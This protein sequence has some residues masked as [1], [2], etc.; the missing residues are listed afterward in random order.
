ITP[1]FP[2]EQS[3]TLCLA[4]LSL[5]TVIGSPSVWHAL[6]PRMAAN[7]AALA[8]ETPA[9]AQLEDQARGYYES[10]A[11]VNL[12]SE[13]LLGHAIQGRRQAAGDYWEG[14]RQRNDAL[15]TELIP[16]WRGTVRGIPT[17]FNRWGMR[18]DDLPRRK[19]PGTYRIAVL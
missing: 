2:L 7:I 10:L 17:Q 11:E 3:P 1:V 5:L 19:P 12:Q 13:P 8:T 4:V 6:G 15:A 18:D 14:T 16:N 9:V